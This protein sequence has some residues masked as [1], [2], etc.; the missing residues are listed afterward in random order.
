VRVCAACPLATLVGVIE[1]YAIE[2]F[3]QLALGSVRVA[4]SDGLGRDARPGD[5]TSHSRLYVKMDGPEYQLRDLLALL[6][7]HGALLDLGD[8]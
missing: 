3:P 6:L 2:G 7:V 1:P 4:V 5:G 8:T